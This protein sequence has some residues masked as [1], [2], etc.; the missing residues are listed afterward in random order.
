MHRPRRLAIVTLLSA[1]PLTLANLSAEHYNFD[2]LGL[3]HGLSNLNV[4]EIAQDSQGY[5]WVATGGGLFRYDGHRFVRH[6]LEQGLNRESIR[7]VHVT[8]SGRVAI[9]TD[10]EF[11]FMSR[12]RFHPVPAPVR[13]GGKDLHFG[14]AGCI[15]STPAGQILGGS[16]AGLL[17][18]ESGEFRL[19]GGGLAGPISRVGGAAAGGGLDPPRGRGRWAGSGGGAGRRP[20]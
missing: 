1:I 14:Q 5:L 13:P 4:R 3:T 20:R 10:D 19:A 15:A 11:G 6:G 7:C 12:G 16:S 9:A 18:M 8:A 2:Q 17:R